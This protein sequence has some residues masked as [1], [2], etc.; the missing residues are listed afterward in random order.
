MQ[1]HGRVPLKC[2]RERADGRT[3]SI[4]DAGGRRSPISR[5]DPMAG[6]WPMVFV[7]VIAVTV[8]TG[9]CVAAAQVLAG[10]GPWFWPVY[11]AVA[12]MVLFLAVALPLR[13]F[14]L[15][16]RRDA[17]Y[18]EEILVHEGRRRE[19]AAR[20]ARALEMAD[21]EPAA[22][23]VAERAFAE[24]TPSTR[25]EVLLADSSQAH[26]VPVVASAPPDAPPGCGVGTPKS[27]PAVRNG[28]A[29]RFA[30]SEQLDACPHLHGRTAAGGGRSGAICVPVSIM[31]SSVGVLHAVH[32][33]ADPLGST[34]AD[35]LEI[36]AQQLG[37][38]VGLL[39]AMS[40]SQ[41]Q[42][43]TDALTGL[44]NRRCLENEVRT[45][46]RRRV[47][48][49]LVL[50]DL[51]HFKRLNDTYGHDAG[52]RALRLFSRTMR[53]AVREGDLVARYGGEEFVVV[54]PQL[55][56]ASGAHAFDRVRLELDAAL[57]DGR[58]P[59]FTVSAG[60]VDTAARPSGTDAEQ[61][62]LDDLVADADQLL[63]RAK[64]EGR[65]RILHSA[66]LVRP[67][68][69]SEPG[70]DSGSGPDAGMLPDATVAPAGADA[71]V[72]D[73]A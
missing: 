18:R 71:T 39:S 31:G 54:M 32:R 56:A 61:L 53:G 24:L 70:R 60:V 36:V 55:D 12:G 14:L 51:D 35:G 26:L 11:A 3:V 19:F 2:T 49:A 47:P 52:D 59:P 58:I 13:F 67:G 62:T 69:A 64:R 30:D 17:E 21:N 9:G 68:S 23:A 43:N 28:H 4:L 41:L 42:A 40:Q 15:R 5:F 45:L 34:E 25:V 10:N 7:N 46:V 22:L 16:Q 20:L 1:P 38:R 48:F 27:C 44:L 66:M 6:T 8:T 37:A 29:L 63:L 50:A 65:N 73:R 72:A 33:Q 57:T